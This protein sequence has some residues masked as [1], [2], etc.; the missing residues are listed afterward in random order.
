MTAIVVFSVGFV[1][2][3]PRDGSG[4]DTHADFF[5]WHDEG[6]SSSRGIEIWDGECCVDAT[7]RK[8]VF[9]SL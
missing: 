1:A 8:R 4:A 7:T 9:P 6:V 5:R 3:W 2:S